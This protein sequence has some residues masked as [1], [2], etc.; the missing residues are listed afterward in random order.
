MFKY[1]T[2]REKRRERRLR[3]VDKKSQTH[4]EKRKIDANVNIYIYN[5]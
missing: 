3:L 1:E 4:G 2:L 5:I